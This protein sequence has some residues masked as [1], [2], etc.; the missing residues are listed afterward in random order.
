MQQYSGT[1]KFLDHANR[2]FGFICRDNSEVQDFL[3]VSNCTHLNLSALQDGVS[4]LRYNLATRPNG[5]AQAVDVELLMEPA[6]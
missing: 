2:G 6:Q 3:H 1:S 5:K 4:R